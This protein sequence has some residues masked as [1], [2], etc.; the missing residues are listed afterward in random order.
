MIEA[1]R[2]TSH[3]L[4]SLLALSALATGC[5]RGQEADPEPVRARSVILFIGDGV[6]DQ[7]LTI[8]RNYLHGA[9]GAL[10]FEQLEHRATARVLTVQEDD[11]TVPEYVGD[12]ASGGTALSA[13]VVTSR[14]RIA[15]AAGSDQDVATIV[16]L[17]KAAGKKTGVVATS[18][19]TDATPASFY[20]HVRFR[21]C[22]GP[23]DMDGGRTPPCPDDKSENGGPGSIGEQLAK[24]NVDVA[25]GGGLETFEQPTHA[26]P[27]MLDLARDNGF[28]IV[29]SEAELA[30]VVSGRV[31]GLF[32]RSHLPVRWQGVERGRALPLKA[33]EDGQRPDVP[34][35]GCE[36]NPSFEGT[37]DLGTLTRRAIELLSAGSG[38]SDDAG[39]FL[40]VESASIDKQAHAA[41][42]CGEI[43]EIQQLEEA[44]Q[45]ALDYAAEHPDTLIMVASDHGHAG[46]VIPYPSLFDSLGMAGGQPIYSPGKFAVVETPEGGVMGVN[47]ATNNGFAEEHTGTDVPIFGQGPGASELDGLIDQTDVFEII[48]RAMEL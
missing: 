1:L 33:K 34:R 48:R 3:F 46:Q 29:T 38:Q 44:V 22:E 2:R 16:E 37:P 10:L 17:A 28:Q 14:G 45:A 6:D 23:E 26:G 15:T 18:S 13:G 27:T 30:A 19:I 9:A 35:F 40:M 31:L 39:F 24:S 11:P 47:Y 41:N 5:A 43:G 32:A 7:Q 12:S 21:F 4:A 20:A 25:L 42:P 8:G 36:P